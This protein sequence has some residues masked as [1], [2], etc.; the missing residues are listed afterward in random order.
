MFGI[1]CKHL[2][3]VCIRH[4]RDVTQFVLTLSF[5]LLNKMVYEK[6]AFVDDN[7]RL[8][9]PSLFF[10]LGSGNQPR[11]LALLPF[12]RPLSLSLSPSFP[13]GSLSLDPQNLQVYRIYLQVSPSLKV[14]PYT[15]PH[16]IHKPNQNETIALKV[17]VSLFVVRSRWLRDRGNCHALK[18]EL[19]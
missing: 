17:N 4:Q 5:I 2:V 3:L 7:A 18:R 11:S 1:R 19:G 12:A 9:V 13:F 8:D 14:W 10:T 16:H 15:S 6:R